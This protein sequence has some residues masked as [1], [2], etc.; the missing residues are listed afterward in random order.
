MSQSIPP[1]DWRRAPPRQFNPAR[2]LTIGGSAVLMV[3][4][5]C[6]STVSLDQFR[7]SIY[8]RKHTYE[9]LIS[10][11]AMSSGLIDMQRGIH[12]Y[13]LTDQE[14]ALVTYRRGAAAL[15]QQLAQLRNL[16]RDNAVQQRRT[17]RLSEDLAA[18]ISYSRRLLETR[19]Q[20]GLQAAADL[21]STGEDRAVIDRTQADL[22]AFAAE[23]HRL[24]TER[25][26]R[27]QEDFRNAARLLVGGSVLAA[28]LLLL[29]H[30]MASR[31]VER[32]RLT[33]AKL[34][35]ILN[36]ANYAIVSTD[37]H[38]TV[39]TMNATAERWL[40][41]RAQE[42]VGKSTPALWHDAD[43]IAA[44]AAALSQ[45]LGT[46]VAPG[47]A[48]FTTKVRPDQMQESEWTI[49]RKDGSRFSGL[50]SATA[51]ADAAG[52]IIGYL[53]VLSDITERK[54]REAEMDRLKR[55]FISTVSHELRTPLTS[56][57]GSLGLVAA[58][59]LGALPEKADAMVRI[60]HH[61]S[62]RLVRIINDI[63]D[64][65]KIESGKLELQ[66]GDVAIAHLL[67]EALESNAPYGEKYQVR[68]A[69]EGAPE[70]AQVRADPDRLMQVLTNLLSNAA[71]FSPAGA[72]VKVR[73]QETGNRVRVEVQD[74]G[75]GI[76]EEFRARIF[77]KFAQADSSSTRRFE[78]TGLGLSISRRLVEAM[79]GTIGFS[80]VTGQGTTFYFD[81]P[82]STVRTSAG[83]EGSTAD[84]SR[85]RRNRVLT[86]EPVSP[87]QAQRP[88]ILHV[89]DDPD[90]SRVIETALAGRADVVCAPTLERAEQA[91]R[92]A[93][94]SLIVLDLE[95]PDGSGLTLLDR[96]EQG[97]SR[98]IPVVILSVSEV[99]L[100]VQGR[101]AAALVKSR[102]SEAEVVGTI[103][104][105]VAEA[106]RPAS[107][108]GSLAS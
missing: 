15:G 7:Q 30:L 4:V 14:S 68:F 10:S 58:G 89:E 74:F 34:A 95:L 57:R 12:G 23:E 13:V 9:I 51:F 76:P 41:Y 92:A 103:L 8:W 94:F 18:L 105:L 82:A 17:E 77:E 50:L 91:L 42:I 104:S 65:E 98:H 1:T 32:H 97:A 45:E 61:N 3:M 36:S 88:R 100:A 22:D 56:I 47:F 73:A 20:H 86:F 60:A 40:G 72:A 106:R 62:E 59:R 39:T 71:K 70:T 11:Q 93:E 75:R 49:R 27:T 37:V 101:V 80:T 90:L 107:P 29:A 5:A 99:P 6:I 102:L 53:G 54:H 87:V 16:T 44:R 48:V 21:E 83:R 81:L 64:V 19:K 46:T 2:W 25:E 85:T 79:G 108:S 33:E 35:A 31:E 67:R 43:E 28:G 38:G 69:L 84:T 66:I 96:L 63:L 78:G 24:L 52:T 55:E 26:A